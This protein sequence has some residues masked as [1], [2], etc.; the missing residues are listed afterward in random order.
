VAGLNSENVGV[1]DLN[2]TLLDKKMERN[3]DLFY[4]R[5]HFTVRFHKQVGDL[6]ADYLLTH[7]KIPGAKVD[8]EN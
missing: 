5:V 8:P 3:G 2:Q 1:F 7:N 6:L 4:D